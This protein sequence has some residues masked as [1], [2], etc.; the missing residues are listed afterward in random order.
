MNYRESTSESSESI[1]IQIIDEPVNINNAI[2]EEELLKNTHISLKK[3][4]KTNNT[5]LSIHDL[6]NIDSVN[7]IMLY[8]HTRC[9]SPLT[10]SN[11][12]SKEGSCNNS[13]TEDAYVTDSS[14]NLPT[15]SLDDISQLTKNNLS[16]IV[17]NNVLHKRHSSK[18]KRLDL[19]DIEKKINQYYSVEDIDNQFTSE[20][21]ILTTYMKGQKNVYVQ[22]KNITQW[23]YNC[24]ML[25]TLIISCFITISTPFVGCDDIRSS[26]VTGLN[27]IIA[28]LISIINFCKLESSTQSFFHLASQYDKLETILE[29]TNGRLLVTDD[30][31]DK[32]RIVIDKINEIEQKILELKDTNLFL[33]PEEIKSLFPIICH[34]NI[35]SFIKKMQNYRH[36]LTVKL[37]DI[38]NEIRYILHKWKKIS[39]KFHDNSEYFHSIE[40]N[41]EKSRLDYLYTIKD[42]IKTDITDFKHAY[43]HMDELFTREIKLAENKTNRWGVW[44]ICFWNYSHPNIEAI[45]KDSNPVIDKYFH[46]IFTENY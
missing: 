19:Y 5:N 21:D 6:E 12:G 8:Q 25:P 35:F 39:T 24:L 7:D 17:N 46:F 32:K 27:A 11:Y 22:S 38:K 2:E 3:P 37:C 20:I 9:D 43:S 36:E 33:I 30:D 31:L 42:K 1:V 34:I 15:L 18:F 44:F 13:D 28:F 10:I 45:K 29:L 41:K 14:N 23:K 16:Q 26:I 4:F 40:Y